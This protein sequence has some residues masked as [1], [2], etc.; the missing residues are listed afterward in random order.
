MS[1]A[2]KRAKAAH[3]KGHYRP[4]HPRRGRRPNPAYGTFNPFFG[5]DLFGML[6]DTLCL[7]FLK[8][9][10]LRD[11]L[12]KGLANKAK[13]EAEECVCKGECSCHNLLQFG[14]TPC[15]P[16]CKTSGFDVCHRCHCQQEATA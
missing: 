14:G 15:P 9:S 10:G 5:T 12:A 1:K 11:A 13:Q 2:S 16:D 6:A 7:G 8:T 3:P 4:R